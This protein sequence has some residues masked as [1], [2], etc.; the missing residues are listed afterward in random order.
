MTEFQAFRMDDKMPE[1]VDDFF[2]SHKII[3][4][5]YVHNRDSIYIQYE[6]YD[7]NKITDYDVAQMAN[8]HNST[9]KKVKTRET[10][11]RLQNKINELEVKLS[12]LADQLGEPDPMVTAP[13]PPPKPKP[14]KRCGFCDAPLPENKEDLAIHLDGECRQQ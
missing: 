2:K 14:A 10:K 9:A 7:S 5:D 1:D 6:D 12:Q 3:K 8:R 11:I 13:P 4:W